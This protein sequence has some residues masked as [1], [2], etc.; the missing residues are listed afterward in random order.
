MPRVVFTPNLQRHIHCP[1][2]VVDGETVAAALETAFAQQ[3]RLRGYIVD[4]HG[5]LRRHVNVFVN[6]ER[7]RDRTC[8]SD[9]VAPDAEIFVMQ[10]LSGG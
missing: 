10:A 9:R 2:M 5:R 8:L 6:A 7:I 4:E 1:A 3:P